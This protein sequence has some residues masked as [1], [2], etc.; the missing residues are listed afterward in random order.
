MEHVPM[1]VPS[2]PHSRSPTTHWLSSRS[3]VK[4]ELKAGMTKLTW[5][6]WTGWGQAEGCQ[7]EI[8]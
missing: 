8:V 1:P 6:R 2:L 3:R 7:Q 4:L 5:A